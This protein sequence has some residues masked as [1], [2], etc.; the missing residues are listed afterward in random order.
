MAWQDR[1]QEWDNLQEAFRLIGHISMLWS[2]IDLELVNLIANLLDIYPAQAL[3][4][5]DKQLP[6]KKA[7]FAKKLIA[8][9][10]PDGEWR[11]RAHA[12]LNKVGSDLNDRRNRYVHD[13]FRFESQ[14]IKHARVG[15]VASKL[16]P[17]YQIVTQ[18][19][20]EGWLDDAMDVWEE[21]MWLSQAL[22]PWMYDKR[23]AEH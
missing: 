21:L 23:M 19:H 14:T 2:R 15:E 7:D 1:K 8:I 18:E 22:V 11:T 3:V 17:S 10:A 20:L 6:G 4:F 5:V 13:I 16:D 12:A 9:E